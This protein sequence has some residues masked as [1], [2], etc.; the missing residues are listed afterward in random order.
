MVY[1]NGM[2][3]ETKLKVEPSYSIVA[4]YRIP[5]RVITAITPTSIH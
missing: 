2:V 3:F 1:D 4:A 5:A